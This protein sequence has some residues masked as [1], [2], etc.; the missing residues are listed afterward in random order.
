MQGA[1]KSLLY[2]SECTA[3]LDDAQVFHLYK[4]AIDNNALEGVT[5][6]LIHDGTGFLQ[7]IEGGEAA[8]D[9]T[10]AK[11]RRDPRHC[12]IVVRD[13][14]TIERRSFADWTMKLVQIDRAHMAAVGSMDDELGPRVDPVIR[15]LILDN[16][17]RMGRAD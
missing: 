17:H 4:T 11:L 7:L 15:A 10:L 12:N 8:V 2:T 1:L 3:P 14:R 13:E 16:V 6:L 9:V 5:G